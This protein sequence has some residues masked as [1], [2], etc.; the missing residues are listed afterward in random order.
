MK[1]YFIAF[2]DKQKN[3][4]SLK[5][6]YYNETDALNSLEHIA[7][8]MIK[9]QQG[10]QQ[11]QICVQTNSTLSD[12]LKD[13]T[14]LSH[15]LF[16]QKVDKQINLYEKKYVES[17]GWLSTSKEAKIDLIGEFSVV[18]YNLED[19]R[20]SCSCNR[21]SQKQSGNIT[22]KTSLQENLITELLE[23]F[24]MENNGLKS[25]TL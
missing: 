9:D 2:L 17:I 6:N 13:D 23:K 25:S 3:S 18:S 16:I 24:K 7:I 20:H 1:Y 15:G 14:K 12:L 11:A 8:E 10:L 5:N 21:S 19:E 4:I 22:I